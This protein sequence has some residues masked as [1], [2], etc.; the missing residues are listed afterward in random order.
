[1]IQELRPKEREMQRIYAEW[2]LEQYEVDTNFLKK[3]FN[4]HFDVS[5]YVK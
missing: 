2:V 1:M 4:S 3:I 5:K